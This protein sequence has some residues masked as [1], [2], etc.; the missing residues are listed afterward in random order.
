MILRVGMNTLRLTDS[1]ES[2]TDR[3]LRRCQRHRAPLAAA[4]ASLSRVRLARTSHLTHVL[5]ATH[6][7]QLMLPCIA[8]S[9]RGPLTP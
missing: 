7:W 6:A 8:W 2:A 1:L 4:S 9:R 3:A 5:M